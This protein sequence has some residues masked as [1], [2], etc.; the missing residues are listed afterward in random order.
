MTCHVDDISFR[1][2]QRSFTVT[3]QVLPKAFGLVRLTTTNDPNAEFPAPTPAEGQSLWVNFVAVGFGRDQGKGQ[4]N[5]SV[6][7]NVL[8]ESGQPTMAKPFAG[9]VNQNIPP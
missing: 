9:E 2:G 7:L 3:Y 4:P 1:G 6:T 8:D 5:L